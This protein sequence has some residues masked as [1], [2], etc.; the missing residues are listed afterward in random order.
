MLSQRL[1]LQRGWA[2]EK[3]TLRRASEDA[4]RRAAEGRKRFEEEAALEVRSEK[5]RRN[6]I[7]FLGN[8]VLG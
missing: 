5:F 4:L 1:E 6:I 8:M 2:E 3:G 7:S